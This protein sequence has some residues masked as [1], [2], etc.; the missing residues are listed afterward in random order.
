MSSPIKPRNRS[1]STESESSE[2]SCEIDLTSPSRSPS[3]KKTGTGL[4]NAGNLT[5][6]Q[7]R[8]ST[9]HLQQNE[10]LSNGT[11]AEEKN[12][13]GGRGRGVSPSS[14]G[15]DSNVE[16]INFTVRENNENTPQRRLT[17]KRSV[18]KP[19]CKLSQF[20]Q[21]YINLLSWCYFI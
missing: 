17:R 18:R 11:A 20:Y 5:G 10:K 16:N 12:E 1:A 21:A 6:R 2:S 19:S 9:R 14:T 13:G 7:T 15:C 4:V 3:K 8:K